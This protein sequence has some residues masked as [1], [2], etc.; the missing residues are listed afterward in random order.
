MK[1]KFKLKVYQQLKIES[2]NLKLWKSLDRPFQKNKS[3]FSKQIISVMDNIF[4][5]IFKNLD[6]NLN[7]LGI[8]TKEFNENFS[9]FDIDKFR[10]LL[11]SETLTTREKIVIESILATLTSLNIQISNSEIKEQF[12]E[13]IRQTLQTNGIKLSQSLD[14]INKRLLQIL[15]SQ[16]LNASGL[17][18]NEIKEIVDEEFKQL[19][20][21]YTKQSYVINAIVTTVTTNLVNEN[22]RAIHTRLNFGSQWITQRDGKV[23]DSH[24][25]ADMQIRAK[26]ELFQVG[27][28]TMPFPSGGGVAKENINCRCYIRAVKL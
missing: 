17:T 22:Y 19:R 5:D 9:F 3:T 6:G 13:Q 28:D 4:E 21:E 24:K 23:R 20:T 12:R 26:G 11:L 8:S 27:T 10:A 2:E 14:T 16:V 18:G 15:Q 7:A 25:V 1:K